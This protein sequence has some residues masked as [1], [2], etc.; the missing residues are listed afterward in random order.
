[1]KDIWALDCSAFR[2]L[3]DKY[4]CH[5]NGEE[6]ADL[7]YTA[8]ITVKNLISLGILNPLYTYADGEERTI[9]LATK[10]TVNSD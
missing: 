7:D 1:M 10:L 4:F 8:W 2:E 9:L 6:Q 5:M 3:T